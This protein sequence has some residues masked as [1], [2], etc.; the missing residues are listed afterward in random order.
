MSWNKEDVSE[1]CM[2]YGWAILA[3]CIVL[4]LL[5][6]QVFF[7][8]NVPEQETPTPS[9]GCIKSMELLCDGDEIWQVETSPPHECLDINLIL[10][11]MK[12]EQN[13]T[14]YVHTVDVKK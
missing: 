10:S 12:A 7:P 9:I 2:N 6:T 5:Y 3:I 4:A 8:S 13:R 1:W 11:T 14:C